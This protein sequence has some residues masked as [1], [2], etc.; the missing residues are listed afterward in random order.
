MRNDGPALGLTS[1]RVKFCYSWFNAYAA[2][3]SKLN[4][5][6]RNVKGIEQRLFEQQKTGKTGSRLHK[7]YNDNRY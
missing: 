2:E 5:T 1:K 6:N 7:K 4:G 3:W